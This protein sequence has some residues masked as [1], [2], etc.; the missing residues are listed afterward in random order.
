MVEYYLNSEVLYLWWSTIFMV[1]YYID[2]GVLY[3]WWSTIFRLDGSILM[4][5]GYED[6][7]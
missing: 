5:L 7:F 2:G 1:E 4:L 3:L 6:I